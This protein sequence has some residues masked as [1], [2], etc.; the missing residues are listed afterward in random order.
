MFDP[1]QIVYMTL[2]TINNV[3]KTRNA[4]DYYYHYNIHMLN[5]HF[6]PL[7]VEFYAP[8][9]Q[10]SCNWSQPTIMLVSNRNRLVVSL[11]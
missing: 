9:D 3:V 5:G 6:V 7:D 2:N 10:A 11:A 8:H 1:S 4:R